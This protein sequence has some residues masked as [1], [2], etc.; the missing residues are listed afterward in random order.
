[1]IAMCTHRSHRDKTA[2]LQCSNNQIGTFLLPRDGTGD[3]SVR[4]EL[5]AQE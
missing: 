2:V 3:I 4:Q 5:P 1:M